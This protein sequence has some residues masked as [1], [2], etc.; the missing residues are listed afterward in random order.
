MNILFLG[1]SITEGIPGVSY[2]DMVK[3]KK[4][5][6]KITNRGKGG[7]TVSSL[8]RRVKRMKDLA[9]YDQIVLFVGVNDIFGKLNTTYKVF[10][11]IKFQKWAKD[12]SQFQSLFT[13]LIEYLLS[14]HIWKKLG[15]S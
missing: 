8:F 10:K 4:S 2:V 1:D 6:W 14:K 3:K 9:S 11:V 12:T 7:D 13:H 5:K 15:S